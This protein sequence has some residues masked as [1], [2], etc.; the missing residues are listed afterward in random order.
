MDG[1]GVG[2]DQGEGVAGVAE[3]GVAG[4]G[5]EAEEGHRA[6]GARGADSAW[7]GLELE[8]GLTRD[9]CIRA[10]KTSSS[11]TR[12]LRHSGSRSTAAAMP[13]SSTAIPIAPSRSSRRC[14]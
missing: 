12:R 3:E 2:A 4:G 13:A 8:T 9:C 14:E 5:V 6:E 10:V 1:A 7:D 11:G